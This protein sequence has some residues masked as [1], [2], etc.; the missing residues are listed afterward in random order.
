M[1]G[2][3]CVYQALLPVVTVGC[4]IRRASSLKRTK[5]MIDLDERVRTLIERG[6]TRSDVV[7]ALNEIASGAEKRARR[8][9]NKKAADDRAL[10]ARVGRLLFFL[11]HGLPAQGAPASDLGLYELMRAIVRPASS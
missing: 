5:L 6:A 10:V 7:Y 8:A 3:R 1:G 11:H 9:D 2:P 4:T